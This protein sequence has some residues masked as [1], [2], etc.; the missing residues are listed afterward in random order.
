MPDMGS[1]CKQFNFKHRS[2]SLDNDNLRPAVA[3]ATGGEIGALA[4]AIL[5]VSLWI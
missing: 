5:E 4:V 1:F 2:A 3:S